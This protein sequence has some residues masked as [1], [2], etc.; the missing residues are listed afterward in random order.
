MSSV[1]QVELDFTIAMHTN[2]HIG[3]GAGMAGMADRVV[4]R[5]ANKELVV[6]ASTIKG[7]TRYHCEQLARAL[8]IGIST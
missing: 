5:M 8:N 6:P 3:S 7:R 4:L 2:F 1:K